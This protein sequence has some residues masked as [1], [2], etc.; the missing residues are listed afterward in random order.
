MTDYLSCP[1]CGTP[2]PV[3]PGRSA[4]SGGTGTEIAQQPWRQRSDCPKPD[5]SVR[6]VREADPPSPWRLD[7]DR[8]PG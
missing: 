4:N 1:K 2:V 6:L 8:A 3:P 7:D 5:C